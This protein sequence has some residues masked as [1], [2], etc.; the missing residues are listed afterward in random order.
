MPVTT[1]LAKIYRKVSFT[2]VNG[3][4]KKDANII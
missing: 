4:K 2:P 3:G 1:T